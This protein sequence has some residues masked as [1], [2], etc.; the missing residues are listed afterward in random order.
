MYLIERKGGEYMAKYC[1][2]DRKAICD[3]CKYYK[4]LYRDILK[5][6]DFRGKGKCTKKGH[7]V[8]ADWYCD[9]FECFNMKER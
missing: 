7:H 5:N 9:D 4:D 6:G 2:Q 8:Y 3:F 1:S